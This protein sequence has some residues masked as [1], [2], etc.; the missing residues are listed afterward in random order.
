M[1]RLAGLLA[2]EQGDFPRAPAQCFSDYDSYSEKVANIERL[3]GG[4]SGRYQIMGTYKAQV[5]SNGFA[6]VKNTEPVNVWDLYLRGSEPE[7]ICQ[8]LLA[9]R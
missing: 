3:L 1:V 2:R 9:S 6:L 7:A 5:G 4:I 8:A